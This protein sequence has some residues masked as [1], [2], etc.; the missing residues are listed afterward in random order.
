MRGLLLKS[1]PG[2]VVDVDK[3]SRTV[4]FYA[5]RFGNVDAHGDV[6]EQG[7]YTQ[8][9]KQW[10]SEGTN[11][12]LHLADHIPTTEHIL[13]RP[14]LEQ[15]SFGLKAYSTIVNT[16][17]GNDILAQYE[18]KLINEH[19]VGFSILKDKYKD[20]G[21]IRYYKEVQLFEVSSVGFGANPD[22]PTL[23][24]KALLENG[25]LDRLEE[26]SISFQKLLKDGSVSDETCILLELY[27]KQLLT[28]LSE[29]KTT[30]QP[31]STQQAPVAPDETKTGL[32]LVE[33][34]KNTILQ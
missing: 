34:F 22:T 3:T 21:G 5:S 32:E 6:M 8:S 28:A 31:P 10:G 16:R 23:G 27:H 26:M 12:I 25:D 13:S 24:F 17:K 11:R 33:L 4:V 30:E 20:D 1:V 15:D 9:I 19:S 7:C 14:V 29:K 2:E 18:A